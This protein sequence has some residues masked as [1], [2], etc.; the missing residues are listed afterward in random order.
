MAPVP[1][2]PPSTLTPPI[3]TQGERVYYVYGGDYRNGY[4]FPEGENIVLGETDPFHEDWNCVWSNG[5]PFAEPANRPMGNGYVPGI[6][7]GPRNRYAP[8]TDCRFPKSI[9][10]LG[11]P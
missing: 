3:H 2:F 4:P 7:H 9:T 8:Y 11:E 1:Y 6:Q 5:Y 10:Q